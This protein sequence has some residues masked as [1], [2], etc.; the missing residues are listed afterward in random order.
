MT[1]LSDATLRALRHA[2]QVIHEAARADVFA[3]YDACRAAVGGHRTR[4][5]LLRRSR[6]RGGPAHLLP[7]RVQQRRLPRGR[8]PDLTDRAGSWRGS[9]PR[10]G[11]TGTPT[12]R[13]HCSIAASGSV[14]R[15]CRRRDRRTDDGAE[16]EG[17]VGIVGALSDTPGAFTDETVVAMQWLATLVLDRVHASHPSRRLNLGLV[18]P[19][20]DAGRSEALTAVNSIASALTS[21]ARE[22]AELAETGSG[23]TAADSAER[24]SS[25]SRRC[26]EIQAML[27]TRVGPPSVESSCALAA[28]GGARTGA[29]RPNRRTE[30]GRW[31]DVRRDLDRSAVR[32]V[33]SAHG[34]W[35][36]GLLGGTVRP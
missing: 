14:T 19:E 35:R 13:A 7:L 1:A 21:M 25:L 23:S 32:S 22:L 33:T 9:W 5:R 4:R 8:R 24:L 2:D 11:P 34:L 30:A 3:V 20:L 10:S 6:E 36:A 26:F 17:L 16:G 12:T 31:S 28:P 27:V 15:S 29:R 18:Y